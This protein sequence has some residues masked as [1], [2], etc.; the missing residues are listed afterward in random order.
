[1]TDTTAAN[2]M[3]DD[4]TRP[5]VVELRRVSKTFHRRGEAIQAVVPVD[6]AV[7]EGQFVV[8]VGESG[9]GKTTLLNIIAGF[10]APTT[11][12]AL[13]RGKPITAP[14]PDRMVMFQEHALF[15]WLTV[16]ENVQFGLR[17]LADL[18]DSQRIRTAKEYLDLVGLADFAHAHVHEISGGQRQRV[19]LARAMAPHPRILLMDEPFNALDATMREEL[20]GKLQEVLARTGQ[21]V[22]FVTHNVR[23][24]ACLADRVIIMAP[25]PGRIIHTLDVPLPRPRDIYDPHVSRY[26]VTIL[27]AL[28]RVSQEG[29]TL[30]HEAPPT[31]LTVFSGSDLHMADGI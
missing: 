31:S 5:L 27:R 28:R 9:C 8:L 22:I 1:M 4:S 18:S 11:G 19:A 14:G 7:H 3:F 16:L 10:E 15:P 12:D 24:A 6:L 23:E 29:S 20:Y 17:N 21:T 13:M 30:I 2:L 26:A 25:R